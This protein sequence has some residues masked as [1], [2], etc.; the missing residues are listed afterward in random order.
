MTNGTLNVRV[1][2][3]SLQHPSPITDCRENSRNCCA[4]LPHRY[5]SVDKSINLIS[6]KDSI[7]DLSAEGVSLVVVDS[8]EAGGSMSDAGSLVVADL[9]AAGD[10][11]DNHA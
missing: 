11:L 2:L 5:A 4:K 10:S 1:V 3:F 6:D 9:S 8:S 7:V